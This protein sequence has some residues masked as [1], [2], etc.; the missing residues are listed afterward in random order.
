MTKHETEAIEHQNAEYLARIK[1][2][3]DQ[4]EAGEGVIHDIID[5][6][7]DE[8]TDESEFPDNLLD[9]L[10]Q[11]GWNGERIYSEEVDWGGFVGEE[12]PW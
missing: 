12:V 11:K 10:I 5:V 1:R 9:Y 3:I 2:S 6:S 8:E 4:L 7:D